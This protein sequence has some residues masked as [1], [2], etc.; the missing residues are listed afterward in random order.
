MKRLLLGLTVVLFSTQVALGKQKAATLDAAAASGANAAASATET[1]A[2]MNAME[3]ML[4][5]NQEQMAEFRAEIKALKEELEAQL[6][7]GHP[8]ASAV[9]A[10]VVTTAP[11]AAGPIAVGPNPIIAAP[12]VA[13]EVPVT[14]SNSPGAPLPLEGPNA[15]PT[16]TIAGSQALNNVVESIMPGVKLSG[17]IWLYDYQPFGLGGVH[18]D[19]NLYGFHLMLDRDE[20]RLGFH[21]EY[22][23]RTT[24][25]RSY[26]PGPTWAEEAYMKVHVPFGT[27]K[28]G[29][30]F[31]QY[32]IFTDYSFYGG[33]PYFDGLKYDP[34][35]GASY[36][37]DNKI[38]DWLS[39][40][41]D[42]QYFRTDARINGSEPGNDVVS[43]PN[44]QRRN[45]FVARVVPRFKLADKVYLAVGPS[46]ERGQ[47]THSSAAT[48]DYWRMGGEATLDVGGMKLYGEV[49]TQN[50]SGPSFQYLPK[51]TYATVGVNGNITPWLSAH[52]NYGQ[53][54]YAPQIQNGE[55]VF[56]GKAQIIQ[57]GLVFALRKGFSLYTEYTYWPL[58]P[59]PG[60]VNLYDRSL[61][62]ELY[63]AF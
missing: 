29:E 52:F 57:P 13:E 44:S 36:E 14:I 41:H 47:E 21:I 22:R 25:L 39:L 18:P 3:E 20:G 40:Q 38:N 35:W 30:I 7:S 10:A 46:F 32:G 60:V 53:G 6:P 58:R 43:D 56:R 42:V 45:E 54:V 15:M 16:Q 23:M 17:V 4:E 62:T 9:A 12:V 63:I 34:E 28:V 31:K 50:Y 55:P 27:V 19:L 49:I 33:L 8:N 61:N 59:T 26:F 1:Q 24:P 2:R 51:V 37:G 11:A 48:N 5:A